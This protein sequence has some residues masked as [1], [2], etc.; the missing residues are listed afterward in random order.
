MDHRRSLTALV[1]AA[2]SAS[3]VSASVLQLRQEV[4]RAAPIV[5]KS[6]LSLPPPPAPPTPAPPGT[7][8][9][10]L[11]PPP[12]P[13]TATPPSSNPLLLPPP[14]APPKPPAKPAPPPPPRAKNAPCTGA[15]RA[16]IRLSTNQ[17]W[18]L[19]DGK[20]VYG[21]VSMTSG[22]P[23]QRTPTGTFSVLWKNKDHRS[24]EFD[25]AP[26]PYS[27]FFAPGGIAFHQGSLR[28]RSAGCVRL[29]LAAAKHFY[30]TLDVG[31]VVQVVK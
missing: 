26:M 28:S 9:L 17:A 18:L 1:V 21:P 30:N 27:V 29:T 14:P 23:G 7:N 25:N 13:P 22:K 3:L 15:A 6:P 2:M 10:P 4:I 19:E 20:V 5:E 31:D 8:A 11:P 16:C 12:A 24:R